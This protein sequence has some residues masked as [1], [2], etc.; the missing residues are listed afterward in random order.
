[1]KRI[2][3][4]ACLIVFAAVSICAVDVSGEF[5]YYMG[6]PLDGSAF[7]ES[8]YDTDSSGNELFSGDFAIDVTGENYSVSVSGN[9]GVFDLDAL[10]GVLEIDLTGSLETIDIELPADVT[11]EVGNSEYYGQGYYYDPNGN[12]TGLV[13]TQGDTGLGV[14]VD[15]DSFDIILGTDVLTLN[16]ADA[17]T[18]ADIVVGVGMAPADGLSLAVSYDTVM[19]TI[20]TSGSIDLTAMTDIEVDT[21]E[22]SY[23]VDTEVDDLS[24]IALGVCVDT[25]IEGIDSTLWY[26]YNNSG[27][28]EHEV[29]GSFGYSLTDEFYPYASVG[30]TDIADFSNAVEYGIGG[31]LTLGDISYTADLSGSTS[32]T[33]EVL[34]GIDLS[35]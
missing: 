11:V 20:A 23:G 3:I 8:G 18:T 31:T 33:P 4:A 5:S 14:A 26:E 24:D 6:I 12:Y 30:C 27:S 19:N 17:S 22:V 35:F 16:D 34:L 10:E 25:S 1:M 29:Y 9:D 13:Y 28:N 15:F 21:L 32:A 2:M 7:Y